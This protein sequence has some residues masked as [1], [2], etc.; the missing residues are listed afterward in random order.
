MTLMTY[1]DSSL[2]LEAGGYWSLQSPTRALGIQRSAGRPPVSV[3]KPISVLHEPFRLE[4]T[5]DPNLHQI[6]VLWFG[7][8][9]I[10][11][12]IAGPGPPVVHSTPTSSDGPLP[13]VTVARSRVSSGMSLCRSL[14]RGA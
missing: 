13:E 7:T 10:T 11:H 5:T 3:R 4:V 12:Y 9:F 1:G 2:V 8:Y 14:Q 6:V